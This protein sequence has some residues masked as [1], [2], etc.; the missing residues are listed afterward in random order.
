MAPPVFGLG[1]LEAIPEMTILGL[2]D[3]S[4]AN[5]DGISGKAN[6][7]WNVKENKMTLGRFGWKAAAPSILQQIA[8]AYKEDMGVTNFLFPVESTYGQSQYINYYNHTDLSDSLLYMNEFYVKT[9]AV[10]ARRNVTDPEVIQGKK[11]FADAN[12]IACHVPSHRTAVNVAFPPLSNQLIFPYTDLLVHDMGPGLADNRPDYLADGQEWRT[13]P[14]WGIG[15]TEVVNG[16][17]NFLHDGRA[18]SFMEAI[19]WHGGEAENSKQY[20]KNL[21]KADR[22]ALV[23]FL[24]SL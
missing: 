7:S 9:L 22:D 23:K 18:R 16:H 11:V 10:P 15:L 4:D 6:R 24:K 21:P 20:V 3:V 14:L 19:L 1:L 5:G 8:E 2:Q 17:S 13:P 12:C